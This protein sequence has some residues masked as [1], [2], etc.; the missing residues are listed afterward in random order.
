MQAGLGTVTIP[1]VTATAKP[2]ASPIAESLQ[3]GEAGDEFSS[4]LIS[5]GQ[6]L[7]QDRF[8]TALKAREWQSSA[9]TKRAIPPGRRGRKRCHRQ[10]RSHRGLETGSQRGNGN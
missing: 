7:T 2:A 10:A 5:T 3:G 4:R 8:A 1:T 6:L 9:Q